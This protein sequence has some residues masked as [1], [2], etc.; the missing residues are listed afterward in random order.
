MRNLLIGR[1]ER[2]FPGLYFLFKPLTVL[3]NLCLVLMV[4]D[5][6]LYSK[7]TET[8]QVTGLAFS[9]WRKIIKKQHKLEPSKRAGEMHLDGKA[10]WVSVAGVGTVSS[11]LK[12]SRTGTLRRQHQIVVYPLTPIHQQVGQSGVHRDV[13]IVSEQH[14]LWHQPH[15]EHTRWGGGVMGLQQLAGQKTTESCCRTLTGGRLALW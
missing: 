11:S 8:V 13:V 12:G 15:L 1:N 9:M 4:R 14:F 3:P 5:N 7:Y 10:G 6:L 2:V